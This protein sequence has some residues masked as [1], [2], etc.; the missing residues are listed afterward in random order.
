MF[1]AFVSLEVLD[2][3]HKR[4]IILPA[5][6]INYWHAA[7]QIVTATCFSLL[8][9]DIFLPCETQRQRQIGQQG[10]PGNRRSPSTHVWFG[11]NY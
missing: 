10:E 3:S 1:A 6:L 11:V 5:Q 4:L 9:R 7:L 2:F 8:L